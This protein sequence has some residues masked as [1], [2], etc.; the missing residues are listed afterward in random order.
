[1][2]ANRE[3]TIMSEYQKLYR[4][5]DERMIAGVCGGLAAHFRVDPTLI[6]LITILFLF[7]GGSAL[8]AYGILWIIVPLEPVSKNLRTRKNE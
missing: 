3:V 6:R 8:L 1:M 2:I 4:S 7:L 5:R